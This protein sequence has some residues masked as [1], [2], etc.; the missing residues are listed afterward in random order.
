MKAE[1][2]LK[3]AQ[4]PRVVD[5][6][7]DDVLLTYRQLGPE[8]G[9]PFSLVHLKRLMKRGAFPPSFRL[10]ASPTSK[11]YWTKRSVLEWKSSRTAAHPAPAPV[12]QD[13][14]VY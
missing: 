12:E 6:R 8:C 3:E 5:V 7:D 10:G 9:I 2:A 11:L 1:E 14:K 13:E 4:K